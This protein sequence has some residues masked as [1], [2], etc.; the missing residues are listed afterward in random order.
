MKTAHTAFLDQ[1]LPH[2]PGCTN[3][4]ALLEI[5]NT[6]IDFCEKS[7]ILQADHD[8]VTALEGIM[9]YDLE[10]PKDYLVTKIMKAWYMGQELDME[11]P[12]EIK[13]PSVY[14]QNSGYL[15]N[16]GDP[17]FLLQKEPRTFSV[18]PIPD[19]TARLALTL[20]VALK[21]TR[22]AST[23]DNIIYE[24]YAETIGHGAVSRLALSPGKPYSDVKLAAARNGLYLAG[25]N[26]ARDRAQ[27]G[28]VR[29]SKHVKM[30]RI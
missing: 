2:V 23:I 21:P 28:N 30:R 9:D 6:I 5:K 26:V 3:E 1:V 4:M 19:E 12:D 8:P 7:L 20:R 24:E 17:R 22:S 14:N 27:K 25:L 29:Q 10:P 18:Y 16:R 13:T 15:V 11:S